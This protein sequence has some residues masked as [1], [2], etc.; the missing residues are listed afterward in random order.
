VPADKVATIANGWT[1]WASFPTW[2]TGG[3]WG[4]CS[5]NENKNCDNVYRA[6]R[7]QELTLTC[8]NGVGVIY[9]TAAVPVNHRI[10]VEAFMK[11]TPNNAPSV[12]EHSIGI[13]PGGGTNPAAAGVQWTHWQEQTSSPPQPGG[14]FNKGTA[15]AVSLGSTITVMLR[16]RAFEPPCHGQTFMLDHVRVY[17]LGPVGPALAVQPG[18][19]STTALVGTNAGDQTFAVSNTGT[20][21]LTYSISDNAAWLSTAPGSGSVSTG[22]DTITVSYST[23]GLSAGQHTATITLTSPEAS[24]SPR[25]VAVTLTMTAK[26]GDFD[27]DGD[28]DHA[29]FGVLQ[30]CFTGPGLVVTDPTCVPADLD[31]D[32]DVDQGDFMLFQ[33]CM[34]GADIPSDPHC[35]P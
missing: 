24:N 26:P 14:V 25:T 12:V 11:F 4:T 19:L 6:D 1:H 16:Q 31:R 13:E 30:K 15:D 7:S 33:N 35:L 27:G 8:A 21:S 34:S 20:G 23:S 10:R 3:Y 28:V 2:P 32:G 29:D 18:S 5:F 22:T 17:D 9:K